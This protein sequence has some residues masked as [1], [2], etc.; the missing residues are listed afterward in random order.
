VTTSTLLKSIAVRQTPPGPLSGWQA[1]RQRL[2]QELDL[3]AGRTTQHYAVLAIGLDRFRAINHSFGHTLGDQL[4]QAVADRLAN[5]VGEDDAVAQIGGD[6]FAVLLTSCA[7]AVRA[8]SVTRSI[9]DAFRA[10][11]LLDGREVVVSLSVGV[12]CGTSGYRTPEECLRDADIA[13]DCAK[14]SGPAGRMV[15]EREMRTRLE[16]AYRLECDL[17][18]A[19]ARREFDVHY[20]PIVRLGDGNVEGFEALVRWQHPSRGLLYP[21][22]FIPLAEQTGLIDPIGWMVLREACQQLAVW[23][24]HSDTQPFVSVNFS[25]RQFLQ[26]DVVGRVEHVLSETGCDARH[27]RLELTET[28]MMENADCVD[29]LSRLSDLDVQLYIDDFGTGYSS[30]SYLHRLPADALKIDRSFVARVIGEPEI[31]ETILALARS[32]DMRVEAEGIETDAQL[33]RLCE[34]GCEFG[35]GFYFSRAVCSAV[36]LTLVDTRLAH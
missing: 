36:A 12:A 24:E 26:P 13:M 6:E 29:K 28:M 27:L 17:R 18:D 20:Q 7:D 2:I 4:L 23:H 3:A 1:F 16:E 33:T 35:Q 32:L 11:F 22:S 21:D 8:S 9:Q 31:V 5:V 19:V 34:L 30:L 25:P 10:P 14:T 15:F